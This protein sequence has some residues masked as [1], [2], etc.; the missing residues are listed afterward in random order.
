MSDVGSTPSRGPSKVTYAGRAKRR[1]S[2]VDKTYKDTGAHS[3]GESD[4]EEQPEPVTKMATRTPKKVDVHLP[5][6]SPKRDTPT[7]AASAKKPASTRGKRAAHSRAGS[8]ASLAREDTLDANDLSPTKPLSSASIKARLQAQRTETSEDG[9]DDASAVGEKQ[10]RYASRKS[11]PERRQFLED[12]PFTG[13]VEHHRAFCKACSEWVELNPTRK[14][15]M[16]NWVEH[17]RQCKAIA[18][19]AMSPTKEKAADDME[20]EVGSAAGG[21]A[22]ADIFNTA[23]KRI[24]KEEDRQAIIE[25]D[26]LAGEV[27]HDTVFCKNCQT[28]VPL[29]KQTRYS[30][31]PWR[32][33]VQKCSGHVPGTRVATA[34]RKMQ[35][36]N[37]AQVKSYTTNSVECKMCDAQIELDGKVEYDLGKWEEHKLSCVPRP[38]APAKAS[39]ST[40][41]RRPPSIASTEDTVVGTELATPKKGTKRSRED[42]DVPDR[43]VRQRGASYEPPQGDA[44]GFLDWITT[45]LKNFLRGFREGLSG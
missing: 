28:W 1:R 25:N 11:E 14:F 43:A 38:P 2:N 4:E 12:D 32:A 27:K 22:G 18:E 13:E 3:D 42:D 36:V 6:P 7:Q 30:L 21:G 41:P 24:K 19:R 23:S 10:G 44:P 31:Y 29:S 34:Q 5:G 8:V 20:D 9:A 15:I 35:L 17:R 33:H 26:P 39:G 16:K 37:D 45:P 40:V